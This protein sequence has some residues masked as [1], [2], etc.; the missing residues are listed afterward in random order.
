MRENFNRTSWVSEVLDNLQNKIPF[1]K[2]TLHTDNK[3]DKYYNASSVKFE[4]D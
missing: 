2:K 3:T 4:E 1:L